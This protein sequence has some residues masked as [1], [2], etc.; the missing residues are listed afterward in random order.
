MS[1]AVYCDFGYVLSIYYIS[2]FCVNVTNCTVACVIFFLA[3]VECIVCCSFAVGGI[4]QFL[5]TG[6]ILE[7]P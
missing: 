2:R 7:V 5:K 1:V 4:R 3:S 6:I